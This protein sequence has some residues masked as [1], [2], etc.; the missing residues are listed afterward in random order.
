[1]VKI[2]NS[3]H[4]R[5]KCGL[6][7]IKDN[8]TILYK[9]N[10]ACITQIRKIYIKSDRTIHISLKFFYT[11]ELQKSGDV[12]VKQIRS[13]NNLSNLFTKTLSIVTFK[14]LVNNIGM[15]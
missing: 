6:S 9:D 14:K 11:H 4:L 3:I 10:V 12:D 2:S 5:E 1:M 13:S 7:T 8:S 15:C